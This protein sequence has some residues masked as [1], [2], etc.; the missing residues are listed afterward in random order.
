MM[1]QQTAKSAVPARKRHGG[2]PSRQASAHLTEDIVD[3]ATALFL[4]SGFEAISIDTIVAEAAISKRTF[5]ARFNGKADLFTAVVV[6]FVEKRMAQLDTVTAG[7]GPL[8]LR[9]EAI[10]CEI[11]RL[12][13]EPDTIALDRVATAEVGRFPELG[14]ILYDFAVPRA[15]GAIEKILD[16]A[17]ANGELDPLDTHHAAE[18]FLYAVIVGPMRLVALGVEGRRL[19][20]ARLKRLRRSVELFLEGVRSRPK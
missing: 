14:R 9:L 20:G 6:R 11:L 2:R 19:S 3:R 1:N 4:R 18:H 13:S 15:A 10:A 8:K 17:C 12:A 7:S 16:Q 5:Y